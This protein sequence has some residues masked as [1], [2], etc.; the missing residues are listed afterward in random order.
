MHH[1]AFFGF[2]V[3]ST[4]KIHT[5]MKHRTNSCNICQ[6]PLQPLQH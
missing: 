6:Q 4:I 5:I 2:E 1:D 3:L